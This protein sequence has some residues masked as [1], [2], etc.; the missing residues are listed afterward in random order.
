LNYCKDFKNDIIGGASNS[1]REIGRL[2]MN[3]DNNFLNDEELKNS[4]NEIFIPPTQKIV[5]IIEEIAINA[6]NKSWEDIV[7]NA[8]KNNIFFGTAYIRNENED[9]GKIIIV[10]LKNIDEKCNEEYSNL[11][12][13]IL[14]ENEERK[15]FG[16]NEWLP[17][18]EWKSKGIDF[19]RIH[20]IEM[21]DN[22]FKAFLRFKEFYELAD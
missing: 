3:N 12:S 20:D 11:I 22:D 21:D 16:L 9:I 6:C 4:E 7:E 18:E 17:D 2:T 15:T 1:F 13:E 5:E 8:V 19:Q 10:N 14:S